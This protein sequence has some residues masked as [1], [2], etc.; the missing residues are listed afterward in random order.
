M[1]AKPWI[2][3]GA[4]LLWAAPAAVGLSQV[5]VYLTE[6][7]MNVVIGCAWLAVLAPIIG[8]VLIVINLRPIGWLAGIWLALNIVLGVMAWALTAVM[9]LQT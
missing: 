1:R 9:A 3:L 2:I 6:T 4:P 8:T 5:R 7:G